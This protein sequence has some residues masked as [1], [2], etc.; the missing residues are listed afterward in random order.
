MLI[1]LSLLLLGLALHMAGALLTLW[2]GLRFMLPHYLMSLL[3]HPKYREAIMR[4]L[5]IGRG[6]SSDATPPR[7]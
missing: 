2:I 1:D 6:T 5:L 3:R 4:G 7:P